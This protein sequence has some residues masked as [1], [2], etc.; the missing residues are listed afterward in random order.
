MSYRGKVLQIPKMK[1]R[2]HYVKARIYVHEY[3]DG[4]LSV[5]HGPRKLAQYDSEGNQ[6]RGVNDLKRA[7]A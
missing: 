2:P 7:A 4:S 5:F 3:A 6:K 1:D